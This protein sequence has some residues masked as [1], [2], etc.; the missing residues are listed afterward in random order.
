M[1]VK[2]YD[3]AESFLES[4]E[5]ILNQNESYNR[6]LGYI[7]ALKGKPLNDSLILGLVD[8]NQTPLVG[9]CFTPKDGF[10]SYSFANA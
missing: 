9:A 7:Y 5:A 1:I 4:F 3:S 8:D 10:L 2:N 6:V